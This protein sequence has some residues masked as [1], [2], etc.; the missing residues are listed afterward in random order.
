MCLNIDHVTR[1]EERVLAVQPHR[2]P[3]GRAS[4]F[5]GQLERWPFASVVVDQH[6]VVNVVDDP[7]LALVW[8]ETNTVT[9]AAVAEEVKIWVGPLRLPDPRWRLN[10]LDNF[11]RFHVSNFEAKQIIKISVH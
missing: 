7:D 1:R 3:V 9:R 8:R 11:A 5:E 6:L 2:Y 10:S 4:R